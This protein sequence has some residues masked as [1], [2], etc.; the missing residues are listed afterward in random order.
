MRDFKIFFYKV[1]NGHCT[2]VEFPNGSNALVDVKISDDNDLDN[3]V[4]RFKEAK[5]SKIDRLIITHPH[6]DHIGGL[7]KIVNNVTIDKF[8]HSPVEFTPDPI[9]DDWKIY[10][11]LKSGLYCNEAIEVKEGWYSTIGDTRIDYLAPT[12]VFLENWPDE[13]N[14]NSLVL[15]I[16]AR[17]HKI[18]IPGDTEEDGWG[19]LSDSDIGNITLLL[20][21]HHGNKSGYNQAKM[22]KMNPAFVVISAGS[23]TECDADDRYRNIARK[24]V[25]TTRRTRIV[26]RI[27]SNNTLHMIS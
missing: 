22:K 16:T 10:E 15:R 1:G 20:A 21:P 25:Y 6:R 5:I 4:D 18:I 2:F 24:K 26:A 19:F 11:D 27:D 8:L 12:K 13:I 3:I 14:N 9:Y 7:I 23:K 17:G